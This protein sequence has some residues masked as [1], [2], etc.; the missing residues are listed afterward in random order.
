[1]F[2][3]RPH[4]HSVCHGYRAVRIAVDPDRVA[5]SDLSIPCLCVISVFIQ[6]MFVCY[7]CAYIT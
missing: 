1:M 7:I 5:G 6:L 3:C 2:Y 4:V